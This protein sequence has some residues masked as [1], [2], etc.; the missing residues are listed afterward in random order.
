MPALREEDQVKAEDDDGEQAADE[1][2]EQ[3]VAAVFD[4]I[5]HVIAQAEDDADAGKGRV[6]PDKAV[7][8]GH[9]HGRDGRFDVAP[10]H[11]EL[12]IGVWDAR[13]HRVDPPQNI[14]TWDR[15]P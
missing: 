12:E 10:A 5:L 6:A 3:T 9:Q 11:M 15:I 1:G 4:G 8:D 14:L 13:E 2:A 7:D